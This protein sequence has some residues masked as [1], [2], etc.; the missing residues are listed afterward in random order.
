MSEM[1]L[2][3]SDLQLFIYVAKEGGLSAAAK[4]SQRSPATL[5]R[6]MHALEKTLGKELFFRH[7]RG[8]ELLAA[9]E[10]LLKELTALES[11]ITTIT[12]VCSQDNRPLVKISAG[13][14]TTLFLIQNINQ[15]SATLDKIL[16]RFISTE[17]ILN[18]SHREVVIGIRNIRPTDESLVCRKLK[19][20]EFAPYSTKD[21]P[22]IWIKV[23]S[24]TPSGRWLDRFVGYNSICEVSE[25]RNSLDLAL[26]NKG[27]AL[28]PTFIGDAQR[29]LHRIGNIIDELGHDQWLVTHHEDRYLPEVKTL[30]STL[31]E[32]LR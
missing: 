14:W 8:Y 7:D 5:G 19:R 4:S 1:D 15:F 30:I 17:K 16:I 29:Q 24:D 27:I 13:T 32:A 26:Q 18:I 21:S 3:W 23:L 12:G 10:K 25:P 9:G 20:V 2:N 31:G 22:E 6:R 28:L 11:Q